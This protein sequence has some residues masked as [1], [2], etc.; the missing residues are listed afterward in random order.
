V[1]EAAVAVAEELDE[2]EAVVHNALTA[3]AAEMPWSL[4]LAASPAEIG[5]GEDLDAAGVRVGAVSPEEAER[6]EQEAKA[7]EAWASLETAAPKDDP[8][9]TDASSSSPS[10]A[11][12]R[13][14]YTLMVED[15]SG[16]GRGGPS[17][18]GAKGDDDLAVSMLL[19]TA[20]VDP[21][22]GQS[23]HHGAAQ[24]L[25]VFAFGGALMTCV[26]RYA[27]A[28]DATTQGTGG[29]AAPLD[30]HSLQRA[31]GMLDGRANASYTAVR[32]G[33]DLADRGPKGPSAAAA[34]F[35]HQIHR[36]QP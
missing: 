13:R 32:R 10:S 28:R 3:P 33:Q 9:A 15:N 8:A 20:G 14:T 35:R 29:K 24:M 25:L 1:V 27:K 6:R 21:N 2:P 7:A 4:P 36:A 17:N 5:A 31:L 16:A 19:R 18:G 30:G 34:G 23:P 26:M 11:Q 22:T 12:S